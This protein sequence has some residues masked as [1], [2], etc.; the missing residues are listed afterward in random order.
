MALW[1]KM[2]TWIDMEHEM[3]RDWPVQ[4]PE[5]ILYICRL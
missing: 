4:A 3:P 2:E 1:E 5:G